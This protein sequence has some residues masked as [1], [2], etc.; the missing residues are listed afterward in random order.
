MHNSALFLP[1][2]P[3]I[4]LLAVTPSSLADLI[5]GWTEKHPQC[6]IRRLR[7]QKCS[8]VARFFDEIGAALQFP[9]YFGENWDAFWECI[10]DLS[11]LWRP[12]SLI[13]VD[14]A[15]LLLR[16]S[17]DGFTTFIRL[18]HDAAGYW[19]DHPADFDGELRPAPFHTLL[20][21]PPESLPALTTRV[22][23]VGLPTSLLNL[24]SKPRETE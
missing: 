17:P 21:C 23:T 10:T 2:G 20:A 15:D 3:G 11:W 12:C 5:F 18:M 24:Q 1:N 9:Y 22:E 6:A 8:D 16:E 4:Q 7:G 13:V 14:R 19:R